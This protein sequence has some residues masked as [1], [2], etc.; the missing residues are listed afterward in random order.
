MR[1]VALEKE[2][3]AKGNGP[4][5]VTPPKRRVRIRRPAEGSIYDILHEHAGLALFVWPCFWTDMHASLLGVR[6]DPTPLPGSHLDSPV[7]LPRSTG[8]HPEQSRIF[9]SFCSTFAD[10]KTRALARTRSMA[11]GNALSS[12]W[13]DTFR[14]PILMPELH[15]FFGDRAYRDAVRPHALWNFP[16]DCA[17]SPKASFTTVST[18]TADSRAAYSQTEYDLSNSPLLCYVNRSQ[19]SAM[20]NIR[21]PTDQGAAVNWPVFRL[22][23]AKAKRTIPEIPDHDVQF[24]A[25]FLAM[26]QRHFYPTPPASSTRDSFWTTNLPGTP[27]PRPN[28]DNITLHILT[29]GDDV[30]IVYKGHVTRKF[31]E[32]FHNPFAAPRDEEGLVCGMHIEYTRVSMKPY[33]DPQDLGRALGDIITRYQYP[34]KETSHYDA[35][36]NGILDEA[37]NCKRRRQREGPDVQCDEHPVRVKKRCLR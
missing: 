25:I 4:P 15:L 21:S 7:L 18:E 31:L 5:S 33:L 35:V 11:I 12:L 23:K 34:T 30:L 27:I 17:C 24:A 13:P 8:A 3:P 22:Q 26:A 32:R 20:R 9:K 28:L 2:L 1:R 16:E 14:E 36:D 19:L 37:S 29:E 6:F 10:K